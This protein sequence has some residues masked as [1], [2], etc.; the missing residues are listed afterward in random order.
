[1]SLRR[2]R[3]DPWTISRALPAEQ[4]LG[5]SDNPASFPNAGKEVVDCL[6]VLRAF[7]SL[8]KR[9]HP[10]SNIDNENETS[11]SRPLFWGARNS[12]GEWEPVDARMWPPVGFKHL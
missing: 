2:P 10:S 5:V 9:S 12:K 8:R 6:V 4:G 1:M 11:F 7:W 3:S